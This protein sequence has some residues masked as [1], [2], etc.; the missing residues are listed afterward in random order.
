[1]LDSTNVHSGG[2]IPNFGAPV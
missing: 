1:M 2:G